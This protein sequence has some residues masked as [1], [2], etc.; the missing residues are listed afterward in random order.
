MRQGQSGKHVTDSSKHH[1]QKFT[2]KIPFDWSFCALSGALTEELFQGECTCRFFRQQERLN[3]VHLPM[4]NFPLGRSQTQWE[5][6][7]MVGAVS[8]TAGSCT[9]T[10]FGCFP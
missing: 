2:G 10:A 7:E 8:M 6:L 9:Q 5:E 1:P 3:F 4:Q